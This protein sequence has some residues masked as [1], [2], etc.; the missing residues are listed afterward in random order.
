MAIKKTDKGWEYAEITFRS[1]EAAEAALYADNNNDEK[2]LDLDGEILEVDQETSFGSFLMPYLREG[3]TI[4]GI[5]K[6]A[7]VSKQTL[8]AW[9]NGDALPRTKN[10]EK[11]ISLLKC[12]RVDLAKAIRTNVEKAAAKAVGLNV[13]EYR[14]AVPR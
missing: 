11:L 13:E 2:K 4:V 12:S 14:H 8:F 3:K 1:K 6:G 9:I 7:G 5:A 10:A